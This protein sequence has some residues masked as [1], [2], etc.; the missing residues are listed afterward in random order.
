M[1]GTD[2]SSKSSEEVP[3]LDPDLAPVLACNRAQI[4][5][6]REPEPGFSPKPVSTFVKAPFEHEEFSAAFQI[7]LD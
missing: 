6:R 1:R 7:K 2:R 3:C 5:I 4:S